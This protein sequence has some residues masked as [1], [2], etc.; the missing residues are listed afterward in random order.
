MNGKNL[1]AVLSDLRALILKSRPA[2]QDYLG[3]SVEEIPEKLIAYTAAI[4]DS[5]T[6]FTISDDSFVTFSVGEQYV[7]GIDGGKQTVQVSYYREIP[8][9]LS[10]DPSA[11]PSSE[12]YW[13][14]FASGGRGGGVAKGTYIGKGFSVSYPGKTIK[15][16]KWDIKR[17]AYD[18]LPEK[19]LNLLAAA[20]ST[21]DAAQSTADAA[22]STADAA[23]STADAAQSTADAAQ[24]ILGDISTGRVQAE[25]LFT[26]DQQT[27]GR[28]SFKFNADNYYKISEFSPAPADVISFSGTRANGKPLSGINAG[29]N[30]CQ[31]GLFVVVTKAGE[32]L[33]PITSTVSGSFTAPSVGLYAKY[34]SGNDWQIAGTAKFTYLH[35]D[36]LVMSPTGKKFR[37]TVDDTGTLSATEV[38]DTTT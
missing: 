2:Y 21:A 38:T 20:Q 36:L 1:S 16:K 9:I 7:V 5:E 22:Q 4:G 23:Q 24:S 15:E 6:L 35:A 11:G 8:A 3:I 37:V 17:L 27:S 26:F 18:L 31:Y 28:D 29:E 19:L 34:Q 33:L 32:C 13:V 10:F 14:I 12:S 25:I 30:C